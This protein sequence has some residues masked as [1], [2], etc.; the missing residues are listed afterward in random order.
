LEAARRRSARYL[1]EE[2]LRLPF[3]PYAPVRQQLL[4]ILRLVN[5]IR[6]RAGR[7]RIDAKVLRYRRRIV[8]PFEADSLT[9]YAESENGD[10]GIPILQETRLDEIFPINS[11]RYLDKELS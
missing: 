1:V 4:N 10:S 5:E 8:R 9:G 6:H 11:E 7:T 3:E 2:F